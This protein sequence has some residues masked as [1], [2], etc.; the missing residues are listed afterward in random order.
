MNS[1]GFIASLVIGKQSSYS[2]Q[3]STVETLLTDT[4]YRWKFCM[5][6]HLIFQPHTKTAPFNF[7]QWDGSCEVT[8][9]F[10]YKRFNCTLFEQAMGKSYCHVTQSEQPQCHTEILSQTT[11]IPNNCSISQVLDIHTLDYVWVMACIT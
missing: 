2:C 9:V 1:A 8:K 4:F 3:Y 5:S 10:C 7:P 6:K 11:H